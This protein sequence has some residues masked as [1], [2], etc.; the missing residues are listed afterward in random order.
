MQG[1]LGLLRFSCLS[2]CF[3][4]SLHG[5]LFFHT[6]ALRNNKLQ[7][8]RDRAGGWWPG[9]NPWKHLQEAWEKAGCVCVSPRCDPVPR[10]GSPRRGFIPNLPQT[11]TGCRGVS[12]LPINALLRAVQQQNCP[13]F[14]LFELFSSA[15]LEWTNLELNPVLRSLVMISQRY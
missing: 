14:F 6:T 5:F 12:V 15:P 1:E 8:S 9:G 11:R 2:L 4:S 13:F 3:L 7:E 10:G